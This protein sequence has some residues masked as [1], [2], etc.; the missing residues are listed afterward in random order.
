MRMDRCRET[1]PPLYE[2]DGL[3]HHSACFLSDPH[4]PVEIR[5]GQLV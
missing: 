5:N 2:V 1:P 4:A 3:S